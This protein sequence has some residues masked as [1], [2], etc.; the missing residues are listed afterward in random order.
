MVLTDSDRKKGF[1]AMREGLTA[2]Q[3]IQKKLNV[4]RP[5]DL[6][7]A[8]SIPE[9]AVRL[10]NAS[11]RLELAMCAEGL[12][13]ADSHVGL[14]FSNA[15]A[16][17]EQIGVVWSHG[18]EKVGPIIVKLEAL[19]SVMI[20]GLVWGVLDR[21]ANVGRMW[22]RP[23]VSGEDVAAKMQMARNIFTLPTVIK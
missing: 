20:L 5:A 16:S 10:S 9:A 19:E 3:R 23:L 18:S 17:G 12:D 6:P 15:T 1:E 11:H 7:E 2:A 21:E 22:A 13:V 4:D 14:L 8:L